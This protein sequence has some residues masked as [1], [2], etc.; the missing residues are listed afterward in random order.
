[1]GQDTRGPV[2]LGVRRTLNIAAGETASTDTVT[3]MAVDNDLDAD[4]AAITIS[5]KATGGNGI[6][7]PPAV[8]L[9]ILDDDAP[10]LVSVSDAADVA[11]GDDTA[12]LKDMR[13]PL[14]LSAPSDGR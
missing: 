4:D 10:P 8:V 9:N 2:A 13:F 7:D 1:M 12:A 14:R 6:A 11:E 3:V 5:A